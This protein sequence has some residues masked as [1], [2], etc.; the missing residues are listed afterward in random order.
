M[1]SVENEERSPELQRA[2]D[3]ARA[4]LQA[5]R[6]QVQEA[7]A[8]PAFSG[9]HEAAAVTSRFRLASLEKV[10]PDR[11]ELES[12]VSQSIPLADRAGSGL[13]T[14]LPEVRAAILPQLVRTKRLGEALRRSAAIA[15][16]DDPLRTALTTFD[17]DGPRALRTL[18]IAPLSAIAPF[19][20]AIRQD[21]S[22]FPPRHEIDRRLELL[23]LLEPFARLVGNDFEGRED[24]LR[25]L[26]IYVDV[27]ES[28]GFL[29]SL[30]RAISWT[31][32][33]PFLVFGVGG[34][35]KSTLIAKF[36]QD[37]MKAAEWQP[38]PF[39]YLDFDRRAVVVDEPAS[40]LVE[41]VRQ[42]GLQ[43]EQ[44]YESA[45]A[46]RRSWRSLLA[47]ANRRTKSGQRSDVRA[48]E[49]IR[50]D[51][52][53]FILKLQLDE[54]LPV[55]LVLDTFE[56][57][58]YRSRAFVET[59]RD[60][61]A[62]LAE[63][64]PKL[65]VVIVGRATV[66]EFAFEKVIELAEFEERSALSF[67]R[68]NGIV[69][70]ELATA[71][72]RQVGGNPLTLRLAAAVF[73]KEQETGTSDIGKLALVR[74]RNVQGQLFERILRHVHNPDVRKI[75]HPGLILRRVTPDIIREVLAGPCG[76]D[77]SAPGRAQE[78]FDELQRE[79]ALVSPAEEPGAVRHRPDVRKLML[80]ALREEEP[81]KVQAIHHGA[82]AFYRRFDDA[83]SRA[84]EIY[85]LL[86]LGELDE[87]GKRFLPDVKASL[88]NAVDELNAPEKALLA[89]LL[90]MEIPEDARASASLEIWERAAVR[91]I[92]E[93]LKSGVIMAAVALLDER[94]ERSAATLLRLREAAVQVALGH[95]ERAAGMLAEAVRAYS[96]AGNGP[97]AFEALLAQ[98]DLARRRGSD[99]AAGAA[100]AEAETL[101][102]TEGDDLW[103][104]RVLIARG[105]AADR[106]PAAIDEIR[107]TAE[108]ID[109][110]HWLR[111]PALLR[112]TAAA[113]GG[114]DVEL[115]H[116]AVRI[117]GGYGL[118]AEDERRL[119]EALAGWGAGQ[120]LETSI[121]Q[122]TLWALGDSPS[123]ANVAD[124]VAR[125]FAEETL[126]EPQPA[127]A[128]ARGPKLK[129]HTDEISTLLAE[130][131]LDE[132]MLS[133]VLVRRFDRNLAAL[134]FSR[135]RHTTFVEVLRRAEGEG[136]LA[137]L[138][139][140]LR[141]SGAPSAKL[142]SALD[143][144]GIGVRAV[145][146]GGPTLKEKGVAE[147]VQAHRTA[148]LLIEQRIC[149]IEV[150]GVFRG[151]GFLIG[152]STVLSSVLVLD[153]DD[154]RE[155]A[156]RFDYGAI[157]GTPYNEGVPCTAR[158]LGLHDEHLR[159]LELSRPIGDE[160]VGGSR[161]SR[162]ASARRSLDL[163][164]EARADGKTPVFWFWHS[165]KDGLQVAGSDALTVTDDDIAFPV[166]DRDRFAG[167]PCFDH[168]F[169]LVGVQCGA[170][171]TRRR[172]GLVLPVKK[173]IE[174]IESRLSYAALGPKDIRLTNWE[175]GEL[176][177]I[178]QNTF[179]LDTFETLLRRINFNF[180]LIELGSPFR[181][182]IREVLWHFQ[183]DKVLDTL[184]DALVTEQPQNPQLDHLRRRHLGR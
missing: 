38:F 167:G 55:L 175:F 114:A 9:A 40:I 136:W 110:D 141:Q 28:Q 62:R 5:A 23:R 102:R 71:I 16:E 168:D 103:L 151:T 33:N 63:D 41:A 179:D 91:R 73:R 140:A 132:W 139:D 43:Y 54:S 157:G 160:P 108:R 46:L 68:K 52:V 153:P 7:P 107:R 50:R 96:L 163:H 56:E 116:K 129:I 61:L 82:V 75:A 6:A 47:S 159:V 45:E 51:F 115:V 14:L 97:A 85:H 133:D 156:V 78:L 93:Y 65:R 42:I 35:G 176:V 150:G 128:S 148:I 122:R 31:R 44:A 59:L 48:R 112:K 11:A 89:D 165:E 125:I 180:Q 32:K 60:F 149:R 131:G 182:M 90:G 127:A 169:R 88:W 172:E 49:S 146:A 12:V 152:P 155:I 164:S 135:E 138:L 177:N 184:L 26:R 95:L 27:L 37:H 3:L 70:K 29:E 18:P 69:D 98:A 76:V 111:E 124:V 171:P 39:A 79:I 158:M 101:A 34:V 142:L 144:L 2:I 173:V 137:A 178:I 121:W 99:A 92:D 74:R 94:T 154:V 8:E 10:A 145:Y 104:L 161:A 162:N 83:V 64:I 100:L 117:A 126:G 147:R 81:V 22:D 181:V 57:V 53:D 166:N 58:Q 87:V 4:K 119:E 134:S 170:H 123:R 86:S 15:V 72:F 130:A 105:P 24:E 25:D 174:R 113:L 118:R 120:S 84:E 80:K 20:D 77:V 21:R 36:I 143:V 67:L 13:W 17:H 1:E 30:T 109:D 66:P 106:E 183:R 19:V